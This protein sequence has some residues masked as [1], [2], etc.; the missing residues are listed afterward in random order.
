MIVQKYTLN[1]LNRVTIL[2]KWLNIEMEVE[3]ENMRFGIY[4]H[5][6]V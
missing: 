2:S 4:L 1:R 3:F 5:Q 6:N